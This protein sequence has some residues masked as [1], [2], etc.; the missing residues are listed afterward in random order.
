MK[1]AKATIFLLIFVI[2]LAPSYAFTES[3]DTEGWGEAKWGMIEKQIEDLY[4]NELKSLPET[5]FVENSYC[6]KV[7]E[8]YKILGLEC[9][10]SFFFLKDNDLLDIIIITK[11]MNGVLF[12]KLK[13]AL[14]DKYGISSKDFIDRTR[15]GTIDEV[16]W[17]L[18]STTIKLVL[19]KYPSLNVYDTIL[20]YKKRSANSDL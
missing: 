17:I 9:T 8:N 6:K 16:L 18:P 4:G 13:G 14:T 19:A 3:K 10:I 15:F 2:L 11:K 5:K 7:L 1:K 20:K 12:V